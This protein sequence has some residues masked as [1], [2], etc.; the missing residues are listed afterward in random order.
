MQSR[1][2]SVRTSDT[3]NVL[4]ASPTI[5]P[6]SASEPQS[7]SSPN[8]PSLETKTNHMTSRPDQLSVDGSQMTSSSPDQ[9]LADEGHVTS[10]PD[11]LLA[12]DGHVT[13]SDEQLLA[14]DIDELE[15]LDEDLEGGKGVGGLIGSEIDSINSPQKADTSHHS[16]PEVT[17]LVQN[18]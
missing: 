1:A 9:L 14:D 13:N 5:S 2:S 18:T 10:S 17:V 8:Q 12:D 16:A 15:C 7:N 11:Q 3:D 6:K 4:S